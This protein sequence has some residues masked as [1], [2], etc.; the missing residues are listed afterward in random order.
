MEVAAHEAVARYNAG[1]FQAYTKIC[2]AMGVQPGALTLHR[3]AEKDAQRA[4]KSSHMHEVKGQRR[5]RLPLHKDT[6]DYS[7]GAF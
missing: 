1:N 7:A 5:K 3:A 2:A 4:R 6:K